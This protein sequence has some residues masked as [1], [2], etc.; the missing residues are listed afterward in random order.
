MASGLVIV[1]R[2][3]ERDVKF[4]EA[5]I[6]LDGIEV[7]NLAFGKSA[8]LSVEAGSHSIQASN[9]MFK[10]KVLDFELPAG[11]QVEFS[12]GNISN[13]CFGILMLLQVAPPSVFLIRVEPDSDTSD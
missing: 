3:D 13:G 5:I 10:S 9:R 8:E 11:G 1:S 2:A 6:L 4:R 12:T 7:A